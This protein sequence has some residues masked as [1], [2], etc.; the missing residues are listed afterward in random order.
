MTLGQD[1]PRRQS[2]PVDFDAWREINPDI[3]V[4]TDTIGWLLF[5]SGE[6]RYKISEATGIP[7]STLS[8]IATGATPVEGITVRVAGR[9]FGYAMEIKARDIGVPQGDEMRQ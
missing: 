6:T 2:R 8:R 3:V 1:K 4:M 9:L 5:E 7:E